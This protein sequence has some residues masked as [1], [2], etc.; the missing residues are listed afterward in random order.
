[1]HHPDHHDHLSRG[2]ALLLSLSL[3]TLFGAL[4]VGVFG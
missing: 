2:E 1:M 4:L 3:L